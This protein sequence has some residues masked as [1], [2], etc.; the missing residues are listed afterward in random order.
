M[1]VQTPDY[2]NRKAPKLLTKNN[3]DRVRM[4]GGVLLFCIIGLPLHMNHNKAP[5][6]SYDDF[7]EK[8]CSYRVPSAVSQKPGELFCNEFNGQWERI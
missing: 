2:A 4:Y 5:E 8:T 7:N 6:R 3:I 1:Q